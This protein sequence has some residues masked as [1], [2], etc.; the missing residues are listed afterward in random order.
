MLAL[1]TTWSHLHAR[2]PCAFHEFK[3]AGVRPPALSI[4]A[5]TP[6]EQPGKRASRLYRA[7]PV[8]AGRGCTRE[9]SPRTASGIHRE[10]NLEPVPTD[11]VDPKST[12]PLAHVHSREGTLGRPDARLHA[13]AAT[14]SP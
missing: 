2:S 9:H 11:W 4:F 7:G 8:P 1:S 14:S 12:T 3:I 5:T 13:P 10:P 6:R